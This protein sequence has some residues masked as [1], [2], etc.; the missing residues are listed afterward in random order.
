MRHTMGRI[1]A[2]LG[3][4]FSHPPLLCRLTVYEETSLIFHRGR[5]SPLRPFDG[6]IRIEGILLHYPGGYAHRG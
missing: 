2:R 3:G 6:V 4:A 1:L 5:I